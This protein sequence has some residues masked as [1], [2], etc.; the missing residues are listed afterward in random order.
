M[1]LSKGNNQGR[2]GNTTM[3][4]VTAIL[5]CVAVAA[6]GILL[7]SPRGGVLE[8]PRPGGASAA[9][10]AASVQPV[11]QPVAQVAPPAAPEVK[12]I[13]KQRTREA[14]QGLQD[15]DAELGRKTELKGSQR[16]RDQSYLYAR[17]D[18]EN[19]DPILVK[20]LKDSIEVCQQGAALLSRIESDV[21][22]NQRNANAATGIGALF[23]A[24]MG[25]DPDSGALAGGI[26]G[27][28]AGEAMKSGKIDEL[29]RKYEAQVERQRAEYN[30]VCDNDKVV[31][32]Q[33][34]RKYG[35]PFID[36]F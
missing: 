26:L 3:V 36:A 21:A 14:W 31:A 35:V 2:P 19:V 29:K 12:S 7:F 11:A 32:E 17:I 28:L 5:A 13:M 8:N 24:L 30:R 27:G 4:A 23:G 34:T 6:V 25:E 33:L 16:F 15:A 1:D 20:H 10:P 18:L 9:G 22:E